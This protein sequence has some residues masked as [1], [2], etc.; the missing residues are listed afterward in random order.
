[1]KRFRVVAYRIDG[2]GYFYDF[3]YTDPEKARDKK[4]ELLATLPASYTV[5]LRDL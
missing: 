5:E 3:Y 1:M 4:A 2:R